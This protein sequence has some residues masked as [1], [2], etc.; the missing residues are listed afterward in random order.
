[1]IQ[2]P[3]DAVS[4]GYRKVGEFEYAQVFESKSANFSGTEEEFVQA[5]HGYNYVQLD[6]Y[7]R[8]CSRAS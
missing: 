1:M 5:G 8:R 7:R 4:V 6:K 3:D 2:I